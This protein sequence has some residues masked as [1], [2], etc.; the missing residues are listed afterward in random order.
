MAKIDVG[1]A[2]S[3]GF[4]LIGSRPLSVVMWGLVYLVIVALPSALLFGFV[5][6]DM[7]NY[8]RDAVRNAGS[9]EPNMA[10]AMAMQ[11]KMG[12]VQ[13][14]IWLTSIAS[15]AV[16]LA[17]VFRAVLTPEDR[18]FFYLRLSM[19]EVRQ[20]LVYLVLAILLG[21]IFFALLLAGALAGVLIF[22][23]GRAAPA[24]ASYVIQF[25][26]IGAVVI[27]CLV[28][29]VLI[30]LRFS[31]AGPM[32]FADKQ[33]R[34]FESWTLTKGHVG[35]LFLVAI[36][37]IAIAILCA[38]VFDGIILGVVLSVVGSAPA[39]HGASIRSF[40]EQSPE[41]LFRTFLPWIIVVSVFGSLFI[42]AMN[43]I[44]LAPWATIY[45]RLTA[46]PEHAFT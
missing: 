37:L 43:A 14:V 38:L 19:A 46:S 27:A 11:A 22:F 4:R 5:G 34:L 8:F 18:G 36:S 3:S 17:A 44:F 6:Q 26:G 29:M 40:F 24:P 10:A 25:L 12:V 2:V 42:G 41:V 23:I 35:E 32:T 1:D 39:D 16:L 21:L 31:L 30:A 15:R 9:G 28:V 7:I 20:G 45:R 33:F 13:P